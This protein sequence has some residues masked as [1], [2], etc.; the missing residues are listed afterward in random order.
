MRVHRNAKLGPAGR[1]ELVRAIEQGATMRQAAACFSVAPNAATS[2]STPSPSP[3]A[4]SNPPPR[5]LCGQR[6]SSEDSLEKHCLPSRPVAAGQA[7]WLPDGD[8]S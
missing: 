3:A 1:R 8:E 5:R 6:A 4:S 7:L 2:P